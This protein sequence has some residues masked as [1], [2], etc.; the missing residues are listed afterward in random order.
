MMKP[1]FL[2]RADFNCAAAVGTIPLKRPIQSVHWQYFGFSLQFGG[3]RRPDSINH[4]SPRP[5]GE[6]MMNQSHAIDDNENWDKCPQCGS[7]V[8]KDPATGKTESCSNCE[9]LASP[10]AGWF[11]GYFLFFFSIGI[12][13]LVYYCIRLLFATE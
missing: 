9:S 11:G 5:Q 2:F 6:K 8:M 12:V 10:T 13:V 4:Q 1:A 3:K 7:P